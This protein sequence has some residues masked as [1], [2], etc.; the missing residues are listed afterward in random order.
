MKLIIAI[1][2]NDDS[3][4]VMPK[5]SE[6]GY[7]ATMLPTT[8]GFLGVGNTTLLIVTEDDR[9][10]ELREL[11]SAYCSTRKKITP[12]T[13]SFGKGLNPESLPEKVTVGGA[14]VFVLDVDRFEK[15]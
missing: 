3:S 7:F 5:L 10:D 4:N 11:F 6:K 14:T 9:V 15:F 13:E 2:S 12:S 1:V 8:G